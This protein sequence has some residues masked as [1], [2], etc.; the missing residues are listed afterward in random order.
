MVNCDHQKRV[1][2]CFTVHNTAHIL[3]LI[4]TNKLKQRLSV[5][6]VVRL[7]SGLACI[8]YSQNLIKS[9]KQQFT[10]VRY[11]PLFQSTA[12]PLAHFVSKPLN[13]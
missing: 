3:I 13:C 9:T 5:C 11:K 6:I 1:F 8:W 4:L 10:V 2:N 7:I 12:M